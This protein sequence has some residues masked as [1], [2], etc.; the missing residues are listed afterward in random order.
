MELTEI[1][2]FVAIADHGTFT[3]AA[4]MLG[5]SQPAISRRITLLESDLG[6]P[7]FER[8]RRGAPLT[9]AGQAFLPY[10][11]SVL[12]QLRDGMD[13]V[14]DLDTQHRGTIVLAMV[15]TLAS[16]PLVM[17]LRTFSEQF[18]Q[19]TL[20]ITTA[21]SHGVERLVSTGE[22]HLG[23]RYFEE[24][25]PGIRCTRIGQERL[26][27]ARAHNSRLVSA[28]VVDT[29][30]LSGLP[31]VSFPL[32]A[33][34]SG[35]GFARVLESHLHRLGL[36]S[37]A[38]IEIDSLTAQKRMI[39]AD[40]GLGLLPESAIAEELRLGTL[41]VLEVED[42]RSTVPISMLQ[43]ESGYTSPAL[44]RLITFLTRNEM[45]PITPREAIADRQR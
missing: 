30:M 5:I 23:L 25:T 35:E 2:A 16:T 45:G 33:T 14:S 17:D 13:A 21:N 15:G 6:A 38:R 42:F 26:I 24:R 3:R 34:S 8:L 39:E 9:D 29:T 1:E 31:W 44:G 12:A 37:L 28:N 32:N 43:R 4:T 18:P 27:V 36:T 20:T 7:V 10:A 11:R 41:E 19:T 22:A 40:F